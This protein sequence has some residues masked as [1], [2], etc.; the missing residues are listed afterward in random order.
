MFLLMKAT[1]GLSFFHTRLS[2]VRKHI[3]ERTRNWTENLGEGNHLYFS[4]DLSELLK[5]K[6]KHYFRAVFLRFSLLGS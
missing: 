5:L 3:R 1:E 2:K 4:S 6:P